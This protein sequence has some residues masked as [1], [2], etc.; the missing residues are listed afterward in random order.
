MAHSDETSECRLSAQLPLF[1]RTEPSGENWLV[2]YRK[3][4]GS[5][6]H[7]CSRHSDCVHMDG[8]HGCYGKKGDQ[9]CWCERDFR[10]QVASCCVN[11]RWGDFEQ[12]LSGEPDPESR[13]EQ[14]PFDPERCRRLCEQTAG[15]LLVALGVQ[16]QQP[17]CQLFA[18]V[19]PSSERETVQQVG[20]LSA[21]EDAPSE[22]DSNLDGDTQAGVSTKDV[23]VEVQAFRFRRD[24]PP[25]NYVKA[26]DGRWFLM[27]L[28]KSTAMEGSAYCIRNWGILYP[29]HSLQDTKNVLALLDGNN[30]KML[31][32]DNLIYVGIDRGA[33]PLADNTIPFITSD[34]QLTITSW[35]PEE[36]NL[37]AQ[38][39]CA[40]VHTG[41]S[42]LHD[43]TCDRRLP[44]VCQRVGRR[45]SGWKQWS[46]HDNTLTVDLG[47]PHQIHA[48]TYTGGSD[49]QRQ[50]VTV[51]TSLQ[52][53]RWMPC[54]RAEPWGA[55]P[56]GLARLL[57]CDR[58]TFGRYVHLHFERA[59][60]VRGNPSVFGIPVFGK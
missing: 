49:S 31:S 44:F 60:R 52:L 54:A 30:F 53:G 57:T 3:I 43:V 12:G 8:P 22:T 48:V 2:H 5:P 40:V 36:P 29:A 32:Y 7:L 28:N 59:V 37:L 21:P 50:A 33:D 41:T 24:T 19:R 51:T 38:E 42:L 6:R 58:V 34:T 35:A 13:L 10:L 4:P 23:K 25:E 26:D 46:E 9:K 18:S 56:Q 16:D 55:A 14:V 27:G 39:Q 20:R 1:N 47:G 11:T 17:V 15:C 45:I